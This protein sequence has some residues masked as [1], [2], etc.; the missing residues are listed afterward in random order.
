MLLNSCGRSLRRLW[1][2]EETNCPSARCPATGNFQPE[3]P[4]MRNAT[5]PSIFRSGSRNCAF[6]AAS[7]RLSA[8]MPQSASRPMTPA[9]WRRLRPLSRA[10]MPRARNSP[11]WSLPCRSPRKTAPAVRPASSTAPAWNETPTSSR[12]DERPS[13]WL[14]RNRCGC[15]NGKT[16]SFS[17]PFPTRIRTSLRLP[18]LRAASWCRRCLSFPAP[19]PAAAKQPISS[20]LPNCS[21]IACILLMPPAARLSTAATC[22]PRLTRNERMDEAQRGATVF[23]KTMPSSVLECVWPLTK[24]WRTLSNCWNRSPPPD[25]SLKIL[26]TPLKREWTLRIPRQASNSSVHG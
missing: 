17:C 14:F 8:R 18:P 13:I 15:R 23:S 11:G 9:V 22:R 12:P 1:P 16:S 5:L 20:F 26:P 2:A 6:S 21:A 4:N 7:A 25:V 24:W 19:V 3:L 10:P